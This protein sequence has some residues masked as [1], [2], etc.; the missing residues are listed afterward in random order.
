MQRNKYDSFLIKKK[1]LRQSI[2]TV[3]V[4]PYV[5][6]SRQKHQNS[7]YK[8]VQRS[9]GNHVKGIKEKQDDSD[10]KNKEFSQ[11]DNYY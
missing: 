11:R 6:S 2:E 3:S 4:S 5:R 9:K 1:K 8:Y 10:L 7:Y